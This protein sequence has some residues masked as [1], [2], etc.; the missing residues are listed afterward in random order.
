METTNEKMSGE[1][2]PNE[3][4]PLA[5][6]VVELL[7]DVSGSAATLALVAAM[8]T[9]A[10]SEADADNP[11]YDGFDFQCQVKDFHFIIEARRGT[12]VDSLEDL[13]QLTLRRDDPESEE[14]CDCPSCEERRKV[15]S[16][17]NIKP[18]IH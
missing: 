1:F 17:H 4:E 10:K 5:E 7:K 18:V 9:I 16:F 8:L 3:I 12:M 14:F 11:D 2:D 13:L 6:K 15:M